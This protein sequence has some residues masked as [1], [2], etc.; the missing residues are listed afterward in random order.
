MWHLRP[1]RQNHFLDTLVMCFALASW[2]RAFQLTPE[3]VDA[4][5]RDDEP[6]KSNLQNEAS[7]VAFYPR[8]TRK[9]KLKIV[10]VNMR[11]R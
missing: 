6:T 3:S 8:I 10:R 4:A 9:P 2:F 1:D 11:S 7:Q 5:V